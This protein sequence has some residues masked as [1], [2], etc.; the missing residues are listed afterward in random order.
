[1]NLHGVNDVRQTGIHTAEPLGPEPSAFEVEMAIEKLKHHKS[2]GTDQIQAELIKARGRTMS[3]EIHKLI[4]TIWNKDK[5]PQGWKELIIGP[6]YKK[7]DKTY[8]S[9]YTGISPLSNTFKMLSNILL[10]RLTPYREEII[11]D[12]QCGL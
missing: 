12:H 5:L 2:P 3:S 7:V 1:M 4:N 9:N 11:G 8:C 6:I 10:S